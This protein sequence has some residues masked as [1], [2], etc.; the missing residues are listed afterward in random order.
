MRQALGHKQI[1]TT[2]RYYAGQETAR[3]FRHFDQTI[4]KQREEASRRPSRSEVRRKR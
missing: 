3:S 2:V 1:D 4:L